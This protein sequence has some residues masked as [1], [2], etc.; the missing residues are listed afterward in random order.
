MCLTIPSAGITE[1]GGF[2]DEVEKLFKVV[3]VV[4]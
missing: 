3:V 4:E 1:K 2:N